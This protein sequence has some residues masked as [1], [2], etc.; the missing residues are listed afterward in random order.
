MGEKRTPDPPTKTRG[1]GG[2]HCRND[3]DAEEGWHIIARMTTTMDI[4]AATITVGTTPRGEGEGEGE[5]GAVASLGGRLSVCVDFSHRRGRLCCQRQPSS[6]S[7]IVAA[8]N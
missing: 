1:G 5:E 3:D 2:H 4:N 7:A 8:I 6:R